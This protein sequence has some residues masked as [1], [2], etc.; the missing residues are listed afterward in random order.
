MNIRAEYGT[1]VFVTEKSL[2]NGYDSD[3]EKAKKYL[4][5]G[6]TYTVDYTDVHSW[7]TNVYLIEFPNVSFNSVCLCDDND[8]D[9]TLMM[10]KDAVTEIKKSIDTMGVDAITQIKKSIQTG[11]PSYGIDAEEK[12]NQI[13]RNKYELSGDEIR[14]IKDFLEIVNDDLD[15]LFRYLTSVYQGICMGN[16]EAAEY[17]K[18]IHGDDYYLRKEQLKLEEI[19]R[20]RKK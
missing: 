17:I 8:K 15:Y 2:E 5:I 7:T 16:F 9:D 3:S 19:E 6:E 11:E 18:D 12:L 4:K 20:N 1:K 14:Q 13:L 10:G